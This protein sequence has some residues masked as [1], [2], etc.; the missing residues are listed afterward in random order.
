MNIIEFLYIFQ[1][2]YSKNEIRCV[3]EWK[4]RL[5]ESNS[6][7]GDK[8][9]QEETVGYMKIMRE[10]R[11]TNQHSILFFSICPGK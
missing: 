4:M 9:D 8:D 7:T 11:Y 2:K 10:M 1:T 6:V 3:G 5:T